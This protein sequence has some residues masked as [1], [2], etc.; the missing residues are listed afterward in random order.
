LTLNGIENNKDFFYFCIDLFCKG[1]V[2]LFGKDNRVEITDI[3]MEQF[4]LLQKKM[5]NAG[6]KVHLDMYEDIPPNEDTKTE[7]AHINLHHIESLPNDLT[8]DEYAFVLRTHQYVYKVNFSL[9]HI[10]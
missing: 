6:I 10:T 7:S 5:M 8:L 4:M 1:L 2:I 3:T 9:H